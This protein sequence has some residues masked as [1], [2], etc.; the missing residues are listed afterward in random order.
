MATNTSAAISVLRSNGL[1]GVVSMKYSTSNR[2]AVVGTDYI[3]ITNQNLVFN[4]NIASNG[5]NVVIKERRYHLHEHSGED[6]QSVSLSSLGNT[7]GATFGISNAVLRL[8]NPNYQGYLTLSATNYSGSVSSGYLSFV[9]NRISGSMGS[10]SVQYATT[11]GTAT[12]GV[13]Y[14]GSTIPCHGTAAM[15]RQKRSTFRSSTP[16]WLPPTSNLASHCSTRLNGVASAPSLGS[17]GDHQRHADDRQRQQFRHPSIQ[18][19]Q[20]Y[21]QRKWRLCHHHRHPHRRGH[22]GDV[23]PLHHGD[24]TASNG[25]IIPPPAA[26]SRWLADKSA[27]ISRFGFQMTA[28]LTRRPPILLQRIIAGPGSLSNAAVQ[29]VDAESYNQPPGSPD[30]GFILR[31]A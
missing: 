8:I 21:R 16:A 27:P 24:G 4:Q 14:T 7:P 18:R 13:D 19:D 29:I 3:G 28:L 22:R 12:N 25:P 26:F 11:N 20:L 10:I 31:R 15:S 5:F 1:F 2:T 9:V 23:G 30:T 17:R 6:R